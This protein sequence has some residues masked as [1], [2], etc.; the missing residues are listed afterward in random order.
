MRAAGQCLWMA[1]HA[2]CLVTTLALAPR[3]TVVGN[4]GLGE[5]RPVRT[6]ITIV[7]SDDKPMRRGTLHAGRWRVP[8]PRDRARLLTD[9]RQ[10][11][12]DGELPP[13]P[14]D[15]EVLPCMPHRFMHSPAR[16]GGALYISV[17]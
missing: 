1:A 13:P 7:V 8:D 17:S 14:S 3:Q 12:G 11:N 5:G 2:I 9:L 15:D 16:G 10:I 6:I 4:I